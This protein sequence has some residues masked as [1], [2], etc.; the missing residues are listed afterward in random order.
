[1]KT[2]SDV[3]A[4]AETQG[5][6][7]LVLAFLHCATVFLSAFLLFAVQPLVARL[8]LPSF[9][10]AASVW[11][12]CML[13]FQVFL[14][15]GYAYAHL[16]T[17]KLEP[18]VQAWVHVSLLAGSIGFL[19]VSLNASLLSVRSPG[20]SIPLILAA[21]IGLPYLALSAT[22]PLVQ[23]WYARLRR[24]SPYRLYALSNLASLAALV[25]YPSL[26]EPLMTL[27][28][29]LLAWSVGFGVFAVLCAA[30][31]VSA[32]RGPG[33]ALCH[34]QQPGT[35]G[36]TFPSS[37]PWLMLAALANALLLATTNHL[38]QNVAAIPFLWVVPLAVY[39]LTLIL[40]F[41]YESQRRRA[42]FQWL[43]PVVLVAM[44][45]AASRGS[46]SA[47]PQLLIPLF[48]A[49]LFIVCMGLHGE[50]VA[51]KPAPAQLTAFYLMIS[52]GGV[53]GSALVAWLAPA[54]LTAVFDLPLL[55]VAT[56]LCLL[57]LFYGRS[58]YGDAV[59]TATSIIAVVLAM[60]QIRGFSSGTRVA[61]RNFYG[62]LRVLDSNLDASGS[63][64]RQLVNGG[65]LHG[66]QF[67]DPERKRDATT[68]YARGTG[69]A[70]ALEECRRGA[71]SVGIIGLGAGTLA[72]FAK[73]GDHYVFFE[74]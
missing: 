47:K 23:V 14:L 62:S 19:P 69:V 28:G 21:G 59:W 7:P 2:P 10:G 11:A 29:Q 57:F 22:S 3:P 46:F 71:Q 15:A 50:L 54:F 17:H 38:C 65:T 25:A 44:G 26:I 48:A 45:Y 27:R 39:L 61:L 31:A 41:D 24:S 6:V 33:P 60:A 67:L 66:S 51:R 8:L 12:A 56:A 70:I 5:A 72:T 4:P 37:L 43:M 74:L 68:Y 36:A 32:R 9:G 20:F 18:R 73:A 49:G 30:V 55:L 16:T 58:W 63:R 53:A 64:I 13:F 42:I 40:C 52:L 35:A 34:E 1:M